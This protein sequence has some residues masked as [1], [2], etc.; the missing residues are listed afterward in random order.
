MEEELKK[1]EQIRKE[2]EKETKNETLYVKILIWAY[3]R[4]EDGFTMA[5]L[6]SDFGLNEDQQKWVMKVFR[7]NNPPSENLFDRVS[8]KKKDKNVYVITSKGTTAAV[9]YLAIQNAKKNNRKNEKIAYW[10]V[11]IAAAVGAANILITL[12]L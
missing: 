6:I 7:P 10:S 8:E 12:I 5:E 9:D 11:F 3:K 2:A 1:R 4:Q